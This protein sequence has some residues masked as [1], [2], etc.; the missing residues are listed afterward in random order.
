MDAARRG[1]GRGRVPW[2]TDLLWALPVLV[3]FVGTPLLLLYYSRR[4]EAATPEGQVK[5]QYATIRPDVTRA[6]QSSPER[7]ALPGGFRL[8]GGWIVVHAPREL[9]MWMA[10]PK[11]DRG[12][13]SWV[14]CV[15]APSRF[16]ASGLQEQ[17]RSGYSVRDAW[18][19]GKG[20][21]QVDVYTWPSWTYVGSSR[22][23]I[24][25]SA[26]HACGPDWGGWAG[27]IDQPV[28]SRLLR[29]WGAELVE[30]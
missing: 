12:P 17:W 9:L 1:P 24:A 5:H 30:E 16:E 10:Q 25:W 6:L 7:R 11:P 22:E 13:L 28:L 19:L 21:C 18:N 23:V 15:P 20:Y 3:A 26:E 29:E 2:L 14:V 8:T 27:R 4:D